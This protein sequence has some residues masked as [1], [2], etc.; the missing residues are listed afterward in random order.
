MFYH[1]SRPEEIK[2]S[3]CG[4][5][6]LIKQ[7]E[8]AYD[9]VTPV[10][11]PLMELK[12]KECSKSAWTAE[13]NTPKKERNRK[14]QTYLILPLRMILFPLLS[15]SYTKTSCKQIPEH[16]KVS[17]QG[18]HLPK[19]AGT[20]KHIS[21]A[22]ERQQPGLLSKTLNVT[23]ANFLSKWHLFIFWLFGFSF[24]SLL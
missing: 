3:F 7:I 8:V 10:R 2:L 17:R 11:E 20:Q 18:R 19:A 22:V 4:W 13:G 16:L 12:L 1:P 15:N 23:R 5:I 9:G 21:C 14:K 6:V 24:H